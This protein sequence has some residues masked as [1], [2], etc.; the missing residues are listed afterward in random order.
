MLAALTFAAVLARAPPTRFAKARGDEAAVA[1]E[2]D[3]ESRDDRAPR[4]PELIEAGAPGALP[5]R[6]GACPAP[7][8]CVTVHLLIP[9]LPAGGAVGV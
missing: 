6:F 8:A 2:R 9:M 4:D 5:M 3:A 7:F 1:A